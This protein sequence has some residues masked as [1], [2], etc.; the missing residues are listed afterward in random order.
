VSPFDQS[1]IFS[2]FLENVVPVERMAIE[3]QTNK[4]LDKMSEEE[5]RLEAE[6]IFKNMGELIRCFET[7][8][9]PG[10]FRFFYIAVQYEERMREESELLL[11]AENM[12]YVLQ[13]AA[14]STKIRNVV[15]YFLS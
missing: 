10:Y 8:H 9:T 15:K 14:A 4:I 3:E 5:K 7:S 6:K 11:S 2:A 13:I 12:V 1:N